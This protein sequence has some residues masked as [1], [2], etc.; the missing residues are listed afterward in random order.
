MKKYR[1][2]KKEKLADRWSKLIKVAQQEEKA[3]DEEVRIYL[4][5]ISRAKHKAVQIKQLTDIS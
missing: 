3:S 5:R 4:D 1:A 2:K